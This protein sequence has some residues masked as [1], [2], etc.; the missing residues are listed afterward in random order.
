WIAR[1]ISENG[2]VAEVGWGSGRQTIPMLRAFA[3]VVAGDLP[4]DLLKLASRKA[5]SVSI[6]SHTDFLV[7]TAP[8]WSRCERPS[9]LEPIFGS[10]HRFSDPPT[11]LIGI[12]RTIKPG[13]Q[14]YILEPHN[15][16]VRFIFDWMMRHW[17][18]WK[19]E[20]NDDP[21]FTKTKFQTLLSAGGL[22]GRI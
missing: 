13:G 9:R 16:P 20:A 17:N 15:S 7:G 11:A 21:L 6:R 22:D 19:E 3:N 1:T 14:F 4:E 18:L 8:N 10:L 12:A 2:L 5:R